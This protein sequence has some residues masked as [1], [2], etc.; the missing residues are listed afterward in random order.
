MLVVACACTSSARSPVPAPSKQLLRILVFSKTAGFRHASIPVAIAAVK[1]LGTG[2]T[3]A[4]VDATEDAGAFTPENLDRYRAVVF[5]LTT[6][7]VLD[8]PQQKAMEDF[9]SGG[10]GFAGVHSATD[11]EYGW[12]WYHEMIGATFKNHP[13][14]QQATVAVE[15]ASHPSTAGLPPDAWNR[16][17]EWYN[18]RPFDTSHIHVLLT[19]LEDTYQGGT[20]GGYHPISWCRGSALGRVWYTAMGHTEA[21]YRDRLFLGHL[22]GGISWAA[23]IADGE[24][25]QAA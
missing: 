15:D 2:S 18:F 4:E 1:K 10:G 13:K 7:D 21:S 5:L 24:C 19:V 9:V 17:D 11:T 25:R 20:M 12:P 14:I 16:T 6:G 22:L 3:L 23:G 8:E